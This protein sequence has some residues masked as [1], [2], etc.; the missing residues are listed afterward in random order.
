MKKS[1]YVWAALVL[2][3]GCRAQPLPENQSVANT[4]FH[5][6]GFSITEK[7]WV[8]HGQ[9]GKIVSH[10]KGGSLETV[11]YENGKRQGVAEW[12]FPYSQVI[13]K[14][15][16][17]DKDRLVSETMHYSN[18]TPQRRVEFQEDGLEQITVWYLNASPQAKETWKDKHLLEATYYDEK[19][20]VEA[21]VTSGT[22]ERLEKEDRALM[23]S[24]KYE[25]GVRTL[26][27][28][29]HP[30]GQLAA[31]ICF[32][33]G[34]ASGQA[35]YFDAKGELVMSENWVAGQR[36]GDTLEYSHGEMIAQIPYVKGLKQ[37][38]EK[39]YRMGELVETIDWLEGKKFGPHKMF[40][41]NQLVKTEYYYHDV[42]VSKVAFEKV[43]LQ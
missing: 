2:L 19:G 3:A 6:Y 35:R 18:G 34:K 31:E 15:C 23:A 36:E 43:V 38:Q 20:A 33:D 16:M 21:S 28:Q 7:E 14:T 37:G 13:A 41:G 11:Q 1:T 24:E 22:G 42:P 25:A 4:Y 8:S 12:T 27:R 9:N 10:L 29:M 5:P 26:K 40:V 17:Y 30:N 32:V 39:R